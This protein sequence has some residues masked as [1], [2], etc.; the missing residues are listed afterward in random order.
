M[1]VAV[2]KRI[3][4]GLDELGLVQGV[5]DEVLN[6]LVDALVVVVDAVVG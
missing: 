2:D 6:I 3:V 4:V 5:V 1:V